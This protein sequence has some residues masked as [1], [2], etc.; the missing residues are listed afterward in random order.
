MTFDFPRNLPLPDLRRT[1]RPRLLTNCAKSG[2]RQWTPYRARV[3]VRGVRRGS[4][5]TLTEINPHEGLRSMT[6]SSTTTEPRPDLR[7]KLPSPGNPPQC[8]TRL[9][10]ILIGASGLKL[11]DEHGTRPALEELCIAGVQPTRHRGR[12]FFHYRSK[13]GLPRQR[14]KT[15]HDQRK[16]AARHWLGV[17]RVPPRAER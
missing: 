12:Q 5:V 13:R 6:G 2:S 14:G 4:A 17:P 11:P 9:A 8:C 15:G 1:L 7:T 16:P 10:M 3:L